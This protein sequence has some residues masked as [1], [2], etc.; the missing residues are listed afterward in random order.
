MLKCHTEDH[1][2]NLAQS[3]STSLSRYQIYQRQYKIEAGGTHRQHAVVNPEISH[4]RN[5][6]GQV[7]PQRAVNRAC[8]VSFVEPRRGPGQRSFALGVE[9]IED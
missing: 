2:S 6:E 1:K 5:Q 8:D 3:V 4:V 7:I 9:D